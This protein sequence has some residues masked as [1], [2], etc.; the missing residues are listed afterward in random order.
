MDAM[1]LEIWPQLFGND[2]EGEGELFMPRWQACI[3]GLCSNNKQ[4]VDV[5]ILLS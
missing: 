5:Y 2:Y 3:E 1:G 4:K